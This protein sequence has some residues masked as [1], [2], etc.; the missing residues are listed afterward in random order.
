MALQ[1]NAYE[2]LWKSFNG[3]TQAIVSIH[4][5]CDTSGAGQTD[6]RW[7]DADLPAGTKGK[8]PCG[9]YW[10]GSN[11][12]DRYDLTLD[13]VEI[14]I[15]SNDEIDRTS[16]SCHELGHTVGLTHGQGGGSGSNIDCM[17]VW[18]SPGT[19][20]TYIRFSQHHKDH[21]NAWF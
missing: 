18:T 14:D 20:L 17:F 4:P 10:S 11:Q 9:P 16:T 8:A 15:G 1:D 7:L 12:C 5:S 13:P 21:I 2:A 3:Q 6:V 19:G